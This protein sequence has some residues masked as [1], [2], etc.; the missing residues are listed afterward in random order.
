[1]YHQ[2]K[3]TPIHPEK[4]EGDPTQV[5]MRSSWETRFAI[6]CDH[7][8][9]IVKWSSE[10]V[11]IPYRCPTDNRL[12]RYFVDFKITVRDRDTKKLKTYL[13]EV[14]PHKETLPPTSRGKKRAQ[15]LKEVMTWGKND[16]K[17]K[18]A[19]EYCKARDWEFVKVTEYELGLKERSK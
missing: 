18:A 8:P 1:M 5:F 11:V 2:R 10:C 3:Y 13:V 17:W 16:A 4:Y 12:H 14:K 7:D 9:S 19:T 6:K 15:Y